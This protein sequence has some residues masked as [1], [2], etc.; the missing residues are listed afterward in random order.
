MGI[1]PLD[2]AKADLQEIENDLVLQ[3]AELGNNKMQET[4]LAWQQQRIKCNELFV[5]ELEKLNNT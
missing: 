2:K 3:I 1:T 5:A 4:F